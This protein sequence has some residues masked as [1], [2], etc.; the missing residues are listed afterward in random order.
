M[1]GL[2]RGDVAATAAEA[3]YLVVRVV[4]VVLAVVLVGHTLRTEAG[5]RAW[6]ATGAAMLVLASFAT[7]TL[8]PLWF[9][10]FPHLAS[11]FPDGRFVPRWTVVA[12]LVCAVPAAVE[13]VS[14]GT[15]SDH[16]WW[17]W[18]AIAQLLVL[19]AQVHRYRRR[20]TT[21]ERE[22]VRWIILG[23]L[24]TMGCFAAAAAAFGGDIGEGSNWSITAANV[25]I[26][27][28]VLG[29]AAG[30]VRPRGLDVDRALHVA[31]IGWVAVPVLAATYAALSTLLSGWW[32]A[33]AVAAAAWPVGL[34][35]GRVADWVVYRGRPDA[36]EATRRMLARLGERTAS[37]SVPAI[38]LDAAVEAVYLDGG[39]ITGTWFEPIERG[40]VEHAAP[41][42]VTY[43]HE[44][45][46]LL[47]L[48]PRRGESGFTARDRRVLDALVG[49]VAPALQGARTHADLLESRVRLVTAREEERRRLRRELHD[50]LGPALSGLSLSAAALTR[51]TG[52]PEAME[53]HRDMQDVVRQT[54]ELAYELRPP[55]LDDHGLVAAILDCTA[56]GDGLDV[57][58]TASEPL[59]LPAAVD[60]AALRIV[61]EAVANTRTHAGASGVTVDL[62]LR[63]GQLEVIVSDDGCGLPQDVRP[64]VGMHSIAERAAELGG[65][66]HYDRDAPGCRLHVTL[67]LETPA[68]YST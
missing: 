42:P 51:R 24:I 27:P 34:L 31:V 3:T 22:S 53:L 30:V 41:F 2:W 28:I 14:P 16:A 23:T 36:M 60:L 56:G 17:R 19:G 68:G 1:A 5:R 65:T 39:R 33:A 67:P 49:Y 21:E 26:L 8:A 43:R 44:E 25:A 61:S 59:A 12:V 20:A 50:S 64:G 45:L 58:V 4:C 55:V 10:A 7:L 52:L 9:V 11:V 46:A 66:A 62:A 6:L 35:A 40:A 32:G 47:E 57:Q 13:L 18:F 54:R 37:T 38:V 15:W 48:S 29:I 63:D